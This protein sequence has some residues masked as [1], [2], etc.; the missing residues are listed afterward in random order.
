MVIFL[1]H[2]DI[3][4]EVQNIIIAYLH[5]PAPDAGKLINAELSEL[6]KKAIANN[7]D[8]KISL[9]EVPAKDFANRI[10]KSY[11]EKHPTVDNIPE[12]QSA[13]LAL[14]KMGYTEDTSKTLVQQVI[15][16]HGS[17][18]SSEEYYTFATKDKTAPKHNKP[19]SSKKPEGPEGSSPVAENIGPAKFNERKTLRGFVNPFQF[20]NLL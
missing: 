6:N 2:K 9:S 14:L 8:V 16:K 3:Y 17:K 4:Q 5:I 1:L 13:F 12:A 7:K 15:D 19:E 10:I 11:V 20:E 18:L